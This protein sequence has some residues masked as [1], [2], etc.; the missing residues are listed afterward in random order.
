[1]FLDLKS[2]IHLLPDPIL[3]CKPKAAPTGVPPCGIESFL[4]GAIGTPD[5]VGE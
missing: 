2:S 3:P 5:W 4:N 1:M